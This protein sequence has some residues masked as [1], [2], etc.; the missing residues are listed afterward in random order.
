MQE[1]VGIGVTTVYAVDLF[2]TAGVG[3]TLSKFLAGFNKI[4]YMFSVIV[5]VYTLECFGRRC[6]YF[7]FPHEFST[8]SWQTAKSA[9]VW[10]AVAMALILL[11]AGILDKFAQVK[12][13][14]QR[15]C[16]AGVTSMAF[17]CTSTFGATWLTNPRPYP[18]GTYISELC[19][20]KRDLNSKCETRFGSDGFLSLHIYILD[21][22]CYSTTYE[23]RTC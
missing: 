14:N 5:A 22:F 1:F 18:T 7:Q 10:G 15:S 6:A 21:V 8:Y 12:G 19:L 3:L 23:K 16:G 9:M 13:P 2:Q 4:S 20:P 11:I 17:L